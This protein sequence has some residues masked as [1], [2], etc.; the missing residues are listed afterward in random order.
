MNVFPDFRDQLWGPPSGAT[1]GDQRVLC[2]TTKEK[3]PY[4]YI[5][6]ERRAILAQELDALQHFVCDDPRI[7][8]IPTATGRSSLSTRPTTSFHFH[9]PSSSLH[10]A[11]VI[12]CSSIIKHSKWLIGVYTVL[13]IG[14]TID[15]VISIGAITGNCLAL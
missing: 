11:R 3:L 1:F 4:I 6:I 2:T 10:R 13:V 12:S 9:L 8:W 14:V 15:T 7:V 5:Y